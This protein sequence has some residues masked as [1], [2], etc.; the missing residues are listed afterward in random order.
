MWGSCWH[1][2]MR[3][4]CGEGGRI[5]RDLFRFKKGGFLSRYSQV[6]V[7]FLVSAM[8]HHVGAVVGLFEDGGFW[9]AVYF[10]VQPVG[11]MVEDL[12]MFVGRK[13]GIEES[14]TCYLIPILCFVK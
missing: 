6:W 8:S 2:M 13:A 14:G 3:R 4:P 9:Q 7:A 1:Q 5:V 10:M 12:V 11:F